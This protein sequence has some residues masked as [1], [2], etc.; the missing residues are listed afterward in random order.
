MDFIAGIEPIVLGQRMIVGPVSP[1]RDAGRLRNDQC[2][3]MRVA[4]V[5]APRPDMA[6]GAWQDQVRVGPD[7]YREVAV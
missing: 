5:V 1:T 3:D 4:L 2:V 7:L 6:Q